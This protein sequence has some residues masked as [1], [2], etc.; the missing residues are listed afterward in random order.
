L[1]HLS[2]QPI[3]LNR[4]PVQ[5]RQIA[6]ILRFADELAEGP[7]RTSMFMQRYH[8]YPETDAIFHQYASITN[9]S[10]DGGNER[11]ALT[12]D[13]DID[14]SDSDAFCENESDLRRILDFTQK[15]ISKLNQE[16]KYARYYCDLLLPLKNITVTFNFW[17]N[18]LP[19]E[20]KLPP[21]TD[22]VV[23]GDQ[24]Q[25]LSSYDEAYQLDNIIEK[26][27]DYFEES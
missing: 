24:E 21:I 22:L 26:V 18:G 25:P 4:K 5:L 6:A 11:I 16:R 2:E 3:Q 19:F 8:S 17:I 15:R 27:R 13:I 1:R 14:A 7:Q 23:P 20:V 12:Y 9:V 10:I